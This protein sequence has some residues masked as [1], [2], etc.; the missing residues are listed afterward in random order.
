M[1]LDQLW[2]VCGVEWTAQSYAPSLH[3]F[4]ASP[5]STQRARF[6]ATVAQSTQQE[7]AGAILL[8]GQPVRYTLHGL[9]FQ[10]YF[11]WVDMSGIYFAWVTSQVYLLLG[12]HFR[13]TSHMVIDHWLYLHSGP[14]RLHPVPSQPLVLRGVC[15]PSTWLLWMSKQHC[16]PFPGE[17]TTTSEHH[18][19]RCKDKW[20]IISKTSGTDAVFAEITIPQMRFHQVL[21]LWTCFPCMFDMSTMLKLRWNWFWAFEAVSY[22]RF[23]KLLP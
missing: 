16:R 19:L 12:Q 21:K 23:L 2:N 8:M 20:A 9:K 7:L 10:V 6:K 14:D 18:L 17:F 4:S 5:S 13:Y 3:F 22:G 1:L 11:A 15:N